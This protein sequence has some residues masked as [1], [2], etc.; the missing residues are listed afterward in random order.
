MRFLG[1]SI[2]VIL[3]LSVAQASAMKYQKGD[4]ITPTDSSY[5]WF[6]K[7]ARVEAVSK[8]DGFGLEKHYILVILD[9]KSNSVVFDQDIENVTRKITSRTCLY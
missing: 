1:I 7:I 5:S 8:I 3:I 4:C 9:Y 6:G 2:A